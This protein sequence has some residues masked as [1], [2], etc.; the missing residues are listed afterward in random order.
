MNRYEIALGKIPDPV[1]KAQKIQ[2]AKGKEFFELGNVVKIP[3]EQIRDRR[4]NLID[5]TQD[6]MMKDPFFQISFVSDP[7]DRTTLNYSTKV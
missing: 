7:M 6:I 2:K 5:R 3:L 1:L 4:F